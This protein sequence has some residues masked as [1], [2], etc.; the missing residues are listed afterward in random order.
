VTVK[1]QP[2]MSTRAD[3]AMDRKMGTKEGSKRD[4]ALDKKRGVKDAGTK[5]ASKPKR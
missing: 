2:K 1:K 4:N 5:K 3:H